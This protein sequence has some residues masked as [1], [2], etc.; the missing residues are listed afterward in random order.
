MISFAKHIHK[1]YWGI[2]WPAPP[3]RAAQVVSVVAA[4]NGSACDHVTDSHRHTETQTH[5]HKDTQT[6]MLTQRHSQTL[7]HRLTDTQI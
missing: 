4:K 1:I 7:G 5:R 2:H 6:Y 3:D